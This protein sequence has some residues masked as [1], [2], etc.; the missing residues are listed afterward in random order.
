V[1]SILKDLGPLGYL[2]IALGGLGAVFALATLGL[3]LAKKPAATVTG[4]L[5]LLTA[6]ATLV[7]GAVGHS[8]AMI[9]V[10]RVLGNVP[11]EVKAEL[12]LKGTLE[13]R[14]HLRVAMI[15]AAL[16]LLVGA[17]ALFIARSRLGVLA[18]FVAAALALSFSRYSAPLPSGKTEFVQVDGIRLP[19]SKAA[20][21]PQ[22]Q[23]LLALTLNGLWL[24]GGKVASVA[25]ALEDARVREQ[26]E[27]V[28]PLA[29]DGRVPFAQL[30]DVLEAASAKERHDFDI[31]V[32]PAAGALAV[33]RVRNT[34][35]LPADP[36]GLPP[37]NLTLHLSEKQFQ[38]SAIGGS[39]DP[40]PLEELGHKM[41]EIKA[42]FPDQT[43]LYVTADP[44]VSMD[45]LVKALDVVREAE[46]RALLFPDVVVGR[47]ESPV[48]KKLPQLEAPSQSGRVESQVPEVKSAE[49]D[50]ER[51]AAYVRA[52]RA[53]IQSCYERELRHDP[54]LQ[55][56]IIARF[57]ITPSGRAA[58]VD[59]TDSTLHND[60]V[61]TCLRGVIGG[62]VFPFKPVSSV[63]IEYPFVF[64][65][66]P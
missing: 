33:I 45:A 58:A 32:Q 42:N 14:A 13:A 51:L 38:L 61:A 65:P 20:R 46:R 39:L 40:Q 55:G 1:I 16:P 44:E 62:F 63:E 19:S 43:M 66:S 64:S 17:L 52:R 48:V 54:R 49:V 30:V 37:M 41:T 21:S 9:T 34:P 28:L 24:E 31:L 18:A 56:K 15:A 26:N 22:A 2:T 53:A 60:A 25:A 29:V 4:V 10:D 3:S 36:N 8:L 59:L 5:C 35:R 57:I 11:F 50:P 7:M 12:L 27:G 47:F 23:P 6:G